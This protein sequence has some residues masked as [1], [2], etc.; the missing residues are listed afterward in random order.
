MFELEVP[1]FGKIN[2]DILVSDFTGTISRDGALIP[3]VEALFNRIAEFMEIRVLTFDSFGTA[4]EAL[5]ELPC[6]VSVLSGEDGA[7]RKRDIVRRLG[8]HRVIALGNGAN[9]RL[10][11]EEARLGIAVI[12]AEGA[13]SAALSASD[14]VARDIVSALELLLNPRRLLATL[15]D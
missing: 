7:E 13:S 2:A 9:D 1:G 4:E 3:G 10:M 11:L 15:R 12:E 14:V 6:A 5:R 8:A